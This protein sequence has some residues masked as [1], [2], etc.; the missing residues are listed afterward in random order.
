[1]TQSESTEVNRLQE[2]L[3]TFTAE[4]LSYIA[5]RPFVRYDKEAAKQIKVAAETVS[6][7]ENKADVD[8]AVKLMLNDGIVTAKEILGRSLARAALELADELDHKSVSVRHKA[9]TEILDRNMGKAGQHID[10]TSGGEKID[11][12][13]KVGIDSDKL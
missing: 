1:M 11:M 13:V 4:Q 6:R 5:V 12:I 8:E 7:W 10:H 3:K 9:A 2:L